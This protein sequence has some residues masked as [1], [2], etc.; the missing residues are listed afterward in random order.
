MSHPM[1]ETGSDPRPRQLAL[2]L[3]FEPAMGAADFMASPSNESALAAVRATPDWAFPILSIVGPPGSG[4]THLAQIW[5]EA[6]G[7]MVVPA[8]MLDQS[9]AEAIISG[10][11]AVV[12]DLP[13]QPQETNVVHDALLFQIVNAAAHGRTK[14]LLTSR[15]APRDWPAATEDLK[16]RLAAVPVTEIE[17]PDD[18]LFVAVIMK[19]LADSQI[20]VDSKAI[21][22]AVAR[23]ERTFEAAR[24]FVEEVARQSV[25]QQ[26]HLTVPVARE[27]LTV[28]SQ[29]G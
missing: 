17:P 21:S 25:S 7:A 10:A 6:E 14:L 11:P 4:K 24:A 12:E 13:I 26:R 8:A 3:S 2:S 16:S 9:T 19:Q 22:Y 29:T 27:A 20:I 15:A 23:L 18:A 1:P 5:A 28:L